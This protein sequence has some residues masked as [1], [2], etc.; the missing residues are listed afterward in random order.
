MYLTRKQ[1]CHPNTLFDVPHKPTPMSAK[2]IAKK[3]PAFAKEMNGSSEDQCLT[4]FWK[5][6]K[7]TKVYEFIDEEAE[8]EVAELLGVNV[9]NEEEVKKKEEEEYKQQTRALTEEEIRTFK[10][11]LAIAKQDLLKFYAVDSSSSE[12]DS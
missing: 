8:E 11:E 3:F 10:E 7:E 5:S 12:L 1:P 2:Q 9:Y 4:Y 6:N